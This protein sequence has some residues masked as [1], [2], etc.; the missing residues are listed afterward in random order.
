VKILDVRDVSAAAD[1]LLAVVDNPRHRHLL[2]NFRRHALLEV[3]GLWPQ[4]LVKEMTVEHPSYR[5]MDGRR[6]R[7][8]DGMTEVAGFYRDIEERGAN[9]FGPLEEQLAVSDWGIF[10]EALAACV[11]PGTSELLADD[12]VEREKAYQVSSYIAIAWPYRGGRLAGE[13]VYEDANSRTVTE[14]DASAITTPSMAR[15]LLAPYL[16]DSPLEEVTQG[17][18]LFAD[19]KPSALESVTGD[20][21]AAS[22]SLITSSGW[23]PSRM[24]SAC[25]R[26]VWWASAFL[27]NACQA[28]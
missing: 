1:A 6:A 12:G 22:T 11:V 4:I 17:L 19:D 7:I 20:L 9:V 2:K 27:G 5:L 23:Q 14:V 24:S 10:G 3:S 8:L 13:H 18:R 25:M 15:E 26:P 16:A 21:F 28:Q